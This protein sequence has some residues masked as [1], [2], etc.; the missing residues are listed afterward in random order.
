VNVQIYTIFLKRWYFPLI[1]WAV[2]GR[3]AASAPQ[4]AVGKAPSGDA[5]SAARLFCPRA[6]LFSEKGAF[7]LK[8]LDTGRGAKKRRFGHFSD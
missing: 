5:K 1:L 8:N 2:G 6:S 4:A 3:R 7:G